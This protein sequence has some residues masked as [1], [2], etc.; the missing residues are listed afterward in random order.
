[1]KLALGAL[2]AALVIV[3]PAAAQQPQPPQDVVP[4]GKI[5]KREA[6]AFIITN[7]PEA[8]PGD[9]LKDD[10]A[11]WFTTAKLRV[12]KARRCDR[13]TA[14]IVSCRFV[15]RMDPDAVHREAGWF[16][17]RCRGSEAVA[18]LSDGGQGGEI[19]GYTCVTIH[20]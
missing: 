15:L 13:E 6:R 17:I 16:P 9:M 14:S 5:T 18:S 19:T 10:R 3:A 2:V 12:E 11:G 1:M 4:K 7:L 20:P 8:A